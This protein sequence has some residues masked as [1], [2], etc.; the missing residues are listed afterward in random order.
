MS[1]RLPNFKKCNFFHDRNR[2]DRLGLIHCRHRSLCHYHHFTQEEFKQLVERGCE[3]VDCPRCKGSGV[4][5]ITVYGL[6]P[7][8]KP[9]D[10]RCISC[11]GD[12]RVPLYKTLVEKADLR[13]WCSCR[14]ETEVQ[15]YDDG[16]H[17]KCKKHCWVCLECNGFTQI[18]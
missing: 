16:R 6:N 1:F 3:L 4:Q 13:K 2:H 14:R 9:S 8:I 5:E 12:K 18:G 15:Y 7:S 10:I 11:N 17:P